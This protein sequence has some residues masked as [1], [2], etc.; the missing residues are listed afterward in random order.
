MAG[1]YSINDARRPP[2]PPYLG[3]WALAS[4]A[5]TSPIILSLLLVIMRLV[6]AINSAN[7]SIE[8]AKVKLA[9]S[10]LG[11]EQ[12]ASVAVSFPHYLADNVNKVTADGAEAIVHGLGQSLIFLFFCSAFPLVC[13]LSMLK[14]CHVFFL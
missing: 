12:S 6:L 5:F 11:L 4:L 8:S 7:A 13:L 10:C 3:P 2:L 1:T 14:P 9:S